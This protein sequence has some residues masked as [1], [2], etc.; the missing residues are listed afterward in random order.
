M[1]NVAESYVANSE[2]ISGTN[3]QTMIYLIT[4]FLL[5]S[6]ITSFGNIYPLNVFLINHIDFFNNKF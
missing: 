2:N 4:I 6:S 1:K 5:S 3:S